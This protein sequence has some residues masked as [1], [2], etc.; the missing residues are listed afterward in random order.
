MDRALRQAELAAQRGE[1]PV[2]AVLAH[3]GGIIAEA[4]NLTES[5]HDAS[6]HAEMLVMRKGSQVLQDWRLSGTVLAVTLEPCS[7]CCGAIKLARIPTVVFGVFDPK[8]GAMGSL[9]DLSQDTRTGAP[10][11]VISGVR[12]G[13]C[14]LL[15]QRFFEERRMSTPAPA[16]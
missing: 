12:A 4:Y 16:R 7:M 5:E 9:Y 14:R 15:L 13:E 10:P 11:R 6:A 3:K 1:V 2:G 8:A